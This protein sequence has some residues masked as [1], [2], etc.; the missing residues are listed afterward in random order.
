MA[1]EKEGEMNYPELTA[2]LRTL[3]RK[4]VRFT[5][6]EKHQRHFELMEEMLCSDRVMVPFDPERDTR[7]YS[8]GGP[9]RGQATVAQSYHHE[10]EG[11]QWRPVAHT[12]MA[13][14][15][16]NYSHSEK[17]SNALLTGIVSNRMYLLGIPLQAVV[18]HK[19]LIPLY[20]TPKRPKQ[21]RIDRYRM[22]LAAYNFKVTHMAGDKIHCDYGS[23]RG[24]PRKEFSKREEEELGVEDDT[25]IY[26]NRIV[27]ELLP[28]AVT[29]N[30]SSTLLRGT[31]LG[32]C[33]WRKLAEGNAGNH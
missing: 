27:K 31:K 24:C 22:K 18:D 33:S 1:A 4:K 23:R 13:W 19:P 32:R 2:P 9:E 5:W 25:E 16:K 3:T 21:M 11:T 30:C 12:A 26:V 6:T 8:D 20:N 15:E 29:R 10:T 28:R 7:L 17:E 14:T